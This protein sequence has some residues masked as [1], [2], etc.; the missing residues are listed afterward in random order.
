MKAADALLLD[1][2]QVDAGRISRLAGVT[3]RD[4]DS[5]APTPAD[6]A[7]WIEKVAAEVQASELDLDEWRAFYDDLAVIF[8]SGEPLYGRRIILTDTGDL[9]PAD[10]PPSSTGGTRGGSRRQRAVF[11]AP[12]TAGTEDDDAVDT[13]LDISPPASLD[14]R[15]VF[16]H[17]DLDWYDGPQQT[18]GRKFLQD[19]RLARQFRTASLLSH[20]GQVMSGNPSDTLKRDS[21]DFAFRLFATNPTKHSKELADVGLAVPVV[22][23]GWRDALGARFSKGW[24]VPGAD[25]L[26]ELVAGAPDASSELAQIAD[27]LIAD[28]SV[29]G[30]ANPNVAKWESFLKVLGVTATLPINDAVESRRFHGR[31]LTADT[32]AADGAPAA[33]PAGVVQQW[34][35]GITTTGNV[36]HP[37]T[38]FSTRSPVYWFAGQHEVGEL[39]GRLRRAYARLV[40]LSV[41][42]LK[43]THFRST[44]S[45]DSGGGIPT[46]VE[47]P[48]GSFLTLGEWVPVAIPTETSRQFQP[49]FETWYVGV[50]DTMAAAYSPLIEPALRTLMSLDLGGERYRKQ[51]GFLDWSDPVDAASLVDHLTALFSRGDIPETANEHLRTSLSAAWAAIGDPSVETR[52]ALDDAL[53][54]ERAGQLT[55]TRKGQSPPDRLYL[56]GTHDQSATARLVRELGWPVV[57]VET[58]D[59]ARLNEVA[60]VLRAHWHDDVEVTSEW[61][62]DVLTDGSPWQ[63][64]EAAP[65]LVDEVPWIPL[66]I[67]ASMRY[68]RASGRV[69]RQQLVRA[70]DQLARIRLTRAHN[71]AIASAGG[72]Q[73]LPARLRGVLPMAGD[74]P[75]LLAEA[76]DTPPTWEQLELLTQ[77]VLELLGQERFKAE[78]SLT[79]RDLSTGSDHA[80]SRPTNVEIA[81]VLQVSEGQIGEVESAV[82]GAVA[83]IVARLRIVTPALWGEEAVELFN[84]TLAA[85]YS[86]DDILHVLSHLAG[87]EKEANSVLAAAADTSDGNALRRRL[88]VALSDFNASLARYFPA[89][90]LVDNGAEQREEFDLRRRQRHR[91]LVDWAR[92]VRI[93]SFDAGE[94]QS[95]WVPVRELTFLEADPGWATTLD[96]VGQDL[97]DARIDDQMMGAL[98]VR[99]QASESLPDY[100]DIRAA[101]GRPMRIRLVEASHVVTAW[102]AHNNAAVPEAWSAEIFDSSLRRRLEHIGALDFRGLTDG[103]LAHWLSLLGAW[104]D[105]MT[106]SVAISAHGL[107]L[108]DLHA[109]ESAEAAAKAEKARAS[110]SVNFQGSD[111]DLDAS[112]STLVDQVANFLATDPTSLESAYRA[113]SL[114]QIARRKARGG[115]REPG[116]GEPSGGVV[117][118]RLSNEQTSAIGLVGEM[119]AFHWLRNRDPSG[120]VDESCWKSGN[121]R[122]VIEGASGNDSLGYDFEVPRRGG[123]VMYEVKA[124]TGD[125]GMIELGETEVRCAQQHSRNDRW[126]LLIVEDVLSPAPRIHMLPNPFHHDS[127]SLFSFDGNSVRLR[128]KLG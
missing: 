119:V 105:G 49:P 103:D 40:V 112:M 46:H 128:F 8:S 89:A 26:S 77:S 71:V 38:N 5:L 15:I 21:L 84:E 98:G 82:F 32:L 97:L 25:D 27:R 88:G 85:T 55:L 3:S 83:G 1:S 20:L 51:L 121:C 116:K 79:I 30:G 50:E 72:D 42:S 45:R 91:E 109:Q 39:S 44:W 59:S 86:R 18:P 2:A 118:P 9:V 113:S 96:E 100:D 12:K 102:C 4:T 101:N 78:V 67:A 110:K 117:S 17:R 53:L 68:P 29:V 111:I 93:G 61:D 52:P 74:V 63:P 73:P 28:P 19:Q 127:R 125:A 99:P 104:P 64:S 16:L 106:L 6:V 76:T 48:L 7:A 94:T 87:D 11:F 114:D 115:D 35:G 123:R 58:S 47:T 43:D 126:R 37:Y 22:A 122:F 56:T 24:N 69:G 80:V 92:L 10:Q 90:A 65:R 95:D 108:G 54:V 36:N 120:V 62:L 23:G 70:L 41:P 13:D 81:E 66:L 31:L 33:V 57:A 14:K 124:T 107:T 34:A 75:T 60:D